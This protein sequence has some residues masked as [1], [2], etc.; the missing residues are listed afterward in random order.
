MTSFMGK[1]LRVDLSAGTA[2]SLEIPARVYE[3]VLAGKGLEAW[4]LYNNIPA[5]ADPLGP[6]NI[7]AF[8]AGALCGTGAFLTGRWTVA[9]KSPLT[10]GW[11]DTNCG[12]LF[13]P[14]IKQCGYDAIFISGIAERPV[15]L[16]CDGKTAEL[17][18][19]SEYWGLD[20]TEAE[21]ALHRELDPV[22]RKKPCVAVIGP[23]GEK[24]SLISGICNEG[25]RIAARCARAT[26][27]ASSSRSRAEERFLKNEGSP[28]S[29]G[30]LK[31]SPKC[32]QLEAQNGNSF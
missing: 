13:A 15:Y 12:G 16:F 17:R 29:R 26:S 30:A 4:Y 25:G 32:R 14:A 20:A 10:G 11:G 21:K 5:G 3:A 23:A 1:V 27:S 8:A 22:C 19:A 18:D 6:E 28:F 9:C 7:L 31:L 24:L 2:E